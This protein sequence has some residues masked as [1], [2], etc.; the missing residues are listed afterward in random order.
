[1]T[2]HSLF[3]FSDEGLGNQGDPSPADAP[4]LTAS[5]ARDN[6]I[7]QVYDGATVN[8]R[9]CVRTAL[10]LVIQRSAEQGTWFTSEHVIAEL[11]D[12]YQLIR[13]P[14]L[15]GAI[16]R[17]AA[18]KG[19]IVPGAFVDGTRPSRHKAPVR[20]WRAAFEAMNSNGSPATAGVDKAAE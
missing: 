20:Q 2:T 18:S 4:A 12:V 19:R 14:R 9:E 11:G 13:E 6:A 7:Q 16:M 15:L 1:M 5:A 10:N 3:D 8:E 17:E